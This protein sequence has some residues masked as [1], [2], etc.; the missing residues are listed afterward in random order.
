MTL[1]IDYQPSK[2]AWQ[3]RLPSPPIIKKMNVLEASPKATK[4]ETNLRRLIGVI[5]DRHG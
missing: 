4:V 1:I 3:L 2:A 5:A